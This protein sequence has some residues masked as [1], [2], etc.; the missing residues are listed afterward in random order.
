MWKELESMREKK[1]NVHYKRNN[2]LVGGYSPSLKFFL[3]ITV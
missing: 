1:W 2:S 3:H